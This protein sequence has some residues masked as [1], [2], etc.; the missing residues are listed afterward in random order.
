MNKKRTASIILNVAI[1]I[2]AAVC[3]FFLY[4]SMEPGALRVILTIAILLAVLGIIAYE[5]ICRS[6]AGKK[7]K[8]RR[9][10]ISVLT[11]LGE[12]NRPIRVWDLT[13]KVGLLIGKSSGEHEV[14]IDLSDTDYHT[15]IDPEHALLNY[16]ESG[17]WLQ[18]T[19]YRN[20]LSIIRQGKEL[21]LGSSAPARIE[22]GDV[23]RVA[24]YTRIAVN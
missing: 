4:S 14:D 3:L 11:L 23:I 7:I 10:S 19:S 6:R 1:V 9:P 16:N 13:G 20:G 15:Y 12:D 8:K 22:P 24:H 17:W 18:D 2:C 5:I 21:V